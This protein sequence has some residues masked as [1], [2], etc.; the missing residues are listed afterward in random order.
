MYL[1][2]GG[3]TGVKL[4]AIFF[5]KRKE[6]KNHGCTKFAEICPAAN[7]LQ[8]WFFAPFLQKN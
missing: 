2:N 5:K 4:K 6:L 3:E 8:P 1:I 7:L